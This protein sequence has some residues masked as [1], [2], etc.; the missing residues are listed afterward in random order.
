[1]DEE[2]HEII[3]KFRKQEYYTL[4]HYFGLFGNQK[5]TCDQIRLLFLENKIC[6]Q[7]TNKKVGAFKEN[8]CKTLKVSLLKLNLNIKNL[9]KNN[10]LIKRIA[11]IKTDTEHN[12]KNHCKKIKKLLAKGFTI[13]QIRIK[14]SIKKF[15][16]LNLLKS[17]GL[18]SESTITDEEFLEKWTKALPTK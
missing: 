3:K 8:A 10:L 9:T 14:L 13:D 18:Q 2:L 7:L 15:K 4:I 17:M 11:S 1:M 6:Q 16:M 12:S 5:L